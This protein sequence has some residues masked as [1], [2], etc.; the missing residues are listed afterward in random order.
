MCTN[1]FKKLPGTIKLELAT[2]TSSELIL[3]MLRKTYDKERTGTITS[4][5]AIK[6]RDKTIQ[7]LTA[8][9]YKERK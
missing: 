7:T 3:T 1:Q 8:F 4:D 2:L 6:Q 9:T 5:E